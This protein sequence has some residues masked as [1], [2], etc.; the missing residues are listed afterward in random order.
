[1]FLGWLFGNWVPESGT[2]GGGETYESDAG[3]PASRVNMGVFFLN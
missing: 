3:A 2:G 1:M